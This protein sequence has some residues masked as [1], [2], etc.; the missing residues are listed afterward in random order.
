MPKSLDEVMAYIKEM[1][2][3]SGNNDQISDDDIRNYIYADMH[4]DARAD[5]NV[6]KYV[7]EL[8]SKNPKIR[9]ELKDTLPETN[10]K[11]KTKMSNLR[12]IAG[13]SG[14]E[15]LKNDFWG[16]KKRAAKRELEEIAQ[17]KRASLNKTSLKQDAKKSISSGRGRHHFTFITN[18]VGLGGH[19]D[20]HDGKKFNTDNLKNNI[21]C[22]T[23]DGVLRGAY[24]EPKVM[25]PSGKVVI[26]FSGSHGS[27]ATYSEDVVKSY[28]KQG[29]PVVTM[30]Y[31]GF[32]KSDTLDKN[33]KKKGTPLSENSIYKD[34]KEMLKY[35]MQT[36][37]VKPENIILHGYSL[38]GAVASKV[39]ADFAQTQQKKALEE[40]RN[41]KKLGGVVLHSPIVSM[42]DA[43]HD[44]F[45]DAFKGVPIVGGVLAATLGHMFGYFAGGEAKMHSGSYNTKEHMRR[46][47]KFDPDIPVH[48]CSGLEAS[49]DQLSIQRTN[50]HNDPKARF[51]N[52]SSQVGLEGHDG[53]NFNANKVQTMLNTSRK[54]LAGPQR[55]AAPNVPGR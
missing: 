25:N 10:K 4:N 6:S 43:A 26:F 31:R 46:L 29:I 5:S 50:I 32:G 36:M 17:A 15:K 55:E 13:R 38:G 19:D 8:M 51:E 16:T 23:P 41:V 42:V 53:N 22:K 1:Q 27:A 9:K 47:H 44:N 18:Y 24:Y 21:E 14:M 40:G 48:Y 37:N 49:G 11:I 35:V 30:D 20:R 39:A 33:G 52:N 34:G 3:S 54:D 28:M 2:K 7:V 12:N 45:Y